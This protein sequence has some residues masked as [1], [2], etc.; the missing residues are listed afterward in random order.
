MLHVPALLRAAD[1]EVRAL[2][3]RR[4]SVLAVAF[5]PDDTVLASGSRDETVKL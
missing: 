4:G 3:G 1:A 5:S 2:K